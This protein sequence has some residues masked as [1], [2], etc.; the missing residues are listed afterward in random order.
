METPDLFP[1]IGLQAAHM[2]LLS[3]AQ[4]AVTGRLRVECSLG[5]CSSMASYHYISIKPWTVCPAK[6]LNLSD[7]EETV[8]ARCQLKNLYKK[9]F[10]EGVKMDVVALLH[11]TTGCNGNDQCN[12][13]YRKHKKPQRLLNYMFRDGGLPRMGVIDDMCAMGYQVPWASEGQG[14]SGRAS[15]SWQVVKAAVVQWFPPWPLL[16]YVTLEMLSL[17]LMGSTLASSGSALES[18]GIDSVRH[19]RS[20]Q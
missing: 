3:L 14:P 10:R 8:F 13:Y 15:W 2:V 9:Q 20:F 18:D 7:H 17:A 12:H 5:S 11:N 1:C 6:G 19:G 4:K 16:K